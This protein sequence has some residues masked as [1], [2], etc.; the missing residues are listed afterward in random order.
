M[1][2]LGQIKRGTT[3][4]YPGEPY[5][6]TDATH[7]KQGRAGAVLR[8]KIKNLHNGN[9]IENTFQGSD[10]IELADLVYKKCQFLYR[11]ETA[12]Y[13]MDQGFEQFSLSN[14]IAGESLQYLREGQNMEIAFWNN[15]PIYIKLPP[16]VDL[17]VT[18]AAPAVKGD[19]ATS[20]SKTV[21]LET[22]LEVLTPMFVKEGDIVRINTETGEYVE[23]V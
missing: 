7:S 17:R 5:V 3:I 6:V 12:A 19:T 11:D 18:E 2:T 22:G 14:N 8:T 4:I 10:K 21:K 13:F 16:K 9:V 1:L 15:Q 20:A 23:R